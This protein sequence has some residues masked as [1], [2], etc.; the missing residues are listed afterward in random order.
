MT[1]SVNNIPLADI[2]EW[3]IKN[4]SQ[5]IEYWQPILATFPHDA[6]VLAIGERNGG[7]S[8]WLASMGFEV[9]CTDIN[10]I[11][12]QAGQLHRQ[13]GLAHKIKYDSLDIVNTDCQPEQFDLII[14]KSVIGGLKSV[15]G[16][17]STRSIE[18]QGKAINNIYQLLKPG[19]HFLSAENLKGGW[20]VQLSRKVTKRAKGWRH[21]SYNELKELF[22]PFPV[23]QT[24]T[25]GILPTFFRS[26]VMNDVAYFLNKYVLFFIPAKS[27][28]IGFTIARKLML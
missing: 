12:E 13:Y 8:L 9:L 17:G 24:K 23:V 22:G 4:W 5:L 6:K 18:A 25:F 11:S 10:D 1:D 20:L 16:R 3:D 27:R 7:L 15:K 19:G 2:V 26:R 14:A 28:Y 21:P